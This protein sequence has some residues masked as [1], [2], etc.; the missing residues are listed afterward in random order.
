[1]EIPIMSPSIIFG[2]ITLAFVWYNFYVSLAIVN[3]L[4][5]N[6]KEANLFSKGFYVKGKIFKYLPLYKETTL[7]K[8]GKVGSLYSQFYISFIGLFIFLALGIL[9]VSG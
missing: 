4:K 5:A 9:T 3:Y 7:Q 1:M 8:E 2:L 6:G